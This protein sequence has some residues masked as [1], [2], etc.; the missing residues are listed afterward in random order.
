MTESAQES[1]APEPEILFHREEAVGVITFNRPKTR[2]ALTFAMYEGLVRLCEEAV[3]G[4]EVKAIVVT[5][6]GGKAFAAGTDIAQFRSFSGAEDALAY[7]ARIDSVLDALESCPLPTIAAITGA[8]TGGGAAIAATCDLRIASYDLK[9][10]LPMAR[11][12][13]NCLS[14]A[15]LAR[16]SVLI[17]SARTR[18]LVLTARLVEAEEA[19]AISLITELVE[20][21]YSVLPRAIELAHTIAGHAPLT[22]Q[23]TKTGLR[24]LR[25]YQTGGDDADLVSLCY[26]SA[27][28][29]EGLEAFLAKRPP[30]WQG[31]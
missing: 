28:F 10:G 26:T 9:F 15:T 20:D 27:D 2:N 1:A 23:A 6:A 5:G 29:R 24:R 11:T 13:G 19:Q 12:L 17:G 4:G 30:V 21:S 22:V 7:E 16:L 14:I 31:K 25:Q 8:C 18:E 3:R